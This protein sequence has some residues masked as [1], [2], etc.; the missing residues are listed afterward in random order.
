MSNSALAVQIGQFIQPTASG[1]YYAVEDSKSNPCRDTLL[2]LMRAKQIPE[3][4][5]EF[6]GQCIGKYSGG[7]RSVF[8]TL[9]KAGFI[10]ASSVPVDMPEK[11]LDTL[12]LDTLPCLSDQERVV[13]TDSGRGFCLGFCGF[14]PTQAEELA[15]LSSSLSVLYERN[16]HLLQS[17]LSINQSAF[18]IIDPAG[19][20][21]LG[22]WPFYIGNNVFTL[23]ISGLPQFNCLAFKQIIWV[24]VQRY[25][26]T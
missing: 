20:S 23:I 3:F 11:N 7:A 9:G 5:E 22:F 25:G 14:T 1:V 4:S 26:Q 13:L 17:Q 21:E 2:R 18:G 19:H 24:L 16:Q 15:V 6:V 8:D 10:S 12:F